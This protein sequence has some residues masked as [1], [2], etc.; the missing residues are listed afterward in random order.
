MLHERIE[1]EPIGRLWYGDIEINYQ[2]A[3]RERVTP[4]VLIRAKNIVIVY[5]RGSIEKLPDG[6]CIAKP[7]P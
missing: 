5:E 6:N 2:V 3:N 4:R 7:M 1:H